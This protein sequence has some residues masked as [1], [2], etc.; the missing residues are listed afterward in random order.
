[1]AKEVNFKE[2]TYQA[3]YD[4][5]ATIK[6]PTPEAYQDLNDEE[7]FALYRSIF[8]TFHDLADFLTASLNIDNLLK[9]Y[10][11]D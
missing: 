7:K 2:V 4:I 8:D 10:S 9:R 11:N 1:M 5:M 6:L 3:R